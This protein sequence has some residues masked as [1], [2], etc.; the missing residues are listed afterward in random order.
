MIIFLWIL[1]EHLIEI[2]FFLKD[3]DFWMIEIIILSIL[4]SK[5]FNAKIYLH[6][7]I[8]II[9]NLLPIILKAI[10]IY[11]SFIDN[12][13]EAED[14]DKDG[15]CYNCTEESENSKLK[16]LYV[17]ESYL[18][19]VG[20]LIYLILIFL[21]AYVNS[22]LKLFMDNKFI[23]EF[24]LLL[25]YGSFGIVISIFACLISTFK[26]CG[27]NSKTNVFNYACIVK[28]DNDTEIYFDSFKVYYD[29][30]EGNNITKILIE[31]PRNL[32][33]TSS[34]FIQKYC[35]IKIIEKLNPIYLIFSFPVYYFIQKIILIITTFI[36]EEERYYI[37]RKDHI[38][39]IWEKFSLDISGDIF[40]IIGFLIYL[41]IIE[42]HFCKLDKNLR[43]NIIA[44]ADED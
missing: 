8:I 44:R 4:Y 2:F 6:H 20:L 22:N 12:C 3:L 32:L 15:Y 16:N 1:E 35:S 39:Y 34:F 23:D 14:E 9:L 41:E 42:L 29:S 43:R 10:S 21:R 24:K 38:N 28:N 37:F 25:I 17:L 40:S 19:P 5:M 26:D 36:K 13:N 27:L 18:I 11:I 31:I 33:A 30:F 7:K